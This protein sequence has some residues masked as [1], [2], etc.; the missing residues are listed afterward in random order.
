[1]SNIKRCR[2]QIL[3]RNL[4]FLTATNYSP[5]SQKR[6]D[7]LITAMQMLEKG[8]TSATFQSHTHFGTSG[9]RNIW[10]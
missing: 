8:L 9:Y 1:M 4:I 6:L 5:W 10:T 3:Q 2:Y 7:G